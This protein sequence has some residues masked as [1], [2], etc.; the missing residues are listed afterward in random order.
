MARGPQ[1]EKVRLKRLR[2]PVARGFRHH[3]VARNFCLSINRGQTG[4]GRCRAGITTINFSCL[5]H[6]R[7]HQKGD[8]ALPCRYENDN[9][10]QLP[11]LLVDLELN[12]K[13]ASE[14]AVH[15]RITVDPTTPHPA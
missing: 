9:A 13:D 2:M 8:N 15:D 1:L 10:V 12:L 3:G 6:R 11:E 4:M 5:Q 14:V 7:N